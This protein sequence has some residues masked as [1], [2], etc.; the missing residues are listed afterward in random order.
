MK[1]MKLDSNSFKFFQTNRESIYYTRPLG[2]MTKVG[3]SLWR[4]ISTRG[5]KKPKIL[6]II[7]ERVLCRNSREKLAKKAKRTE[8]KTTKKVDFVTLMEK[9]DN[10]AR[11]HVYFV[12]VCLR[13]ASLHL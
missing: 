9:I 13:L 3:K 6:P 12:I 10:E 1:I 7:L 4:K 8:G 2:N 5:K 11:K